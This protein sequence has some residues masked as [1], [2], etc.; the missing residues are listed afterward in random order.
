MSS[1]SLHHPKN[2]CTILKIIDHKGKTIGS[3]SGDYD[4]IAL[5]HPGLSKPLRAQANPMNDVKF[6]I[7]HP[8]Q[9]FFQ[10]FRP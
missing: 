6:A 3:I 9:R 7:D 4:T 8:S 10:G 5:N 1:K 2:H